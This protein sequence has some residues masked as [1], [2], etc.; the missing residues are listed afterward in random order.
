MECEAEKRRLQNQ[1]ELAAER[2]RASKELRGREIKRLSEA[3]LGNAN[4]YLEMPPR[5]FEDAVA[6]LF[7]RLGYKV[8]QTPFTRDGGKD[9]ILRKGGKKYLLECKRYGPA[10]GVGRRDLQILFAAMHAE[11]AA[12]GFCVTTGSFTSTAKE[13]AA[14]VNITLYDWSR[15]AFLVNEAYPE[16]ADFS[17]ASVMCRECGLVTTVPVDVLPASAQCRN[18]HAVT[19]NIVI[20]DFRIL[21]EAEVPYCETCGAPMRLVKWHGREF[22]GCTSYP[23]CRSTK[24]LRSRAQ[25]SLVLRR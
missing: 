23:K 19:S 14:A 9:A 7:R 4:T 5:Q 6:E 8:K 25:D 22:W 13:Y 20:A 15:L 24:P 16:S 1:W 12:G 18:G 2:E 21:A 3:W 10:Q 17:E 11:G